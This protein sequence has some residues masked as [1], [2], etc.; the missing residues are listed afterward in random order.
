MSPLLLLVVGVAGA[1]VP[2]DQ[3]TAV[4][5]PADG[6]ADAPWYLLQVPGTWVDLLVSNDGGHFWDEIAGPPLADD[7]VDVARFGDTV[8]LLGETAVW[9]SAD[10]AATWASRA[11]P[12]PMTRVVAGAAEL[13]Y[14]GDSGVWVATSPSEA[15]VAALDV[16][17]VV[18]LEHGPFGAAAVF[19]GGEVWVAADARDWTGL[20]TVAG[21]TSV[22]IAA[23]AVYVG[24]DA[25]N[26]WRDDGAGFIAC[27]AVPID[28]E[29]PAIVEIAAA[30]GRLY[31]ATATAA[32]YVS[33]DDCA[34]FGDAV[35][36]EAEVGTYG[37]AKTSRL[38]FT[39]LFATDTDV[40]LAGWP[41]VAISRD[42]GET[43]YA[44]NIAPPD[45][46]RGLAW[47]PT[48]RVF[49]GGNDAGPVYTDD[50]GATYVVRGG[51]LTDGNVQ[52]IA[53]DP[54]DPVRVYAIVNH[55]LWRSDD[56]G[57]SW[58]GVSGSAIVGSVWAFADEVWAMWVED[59]ASR[60]VTSTDGFATVTDWPGL[61]DALAGEEPAT[62]ARVA[63]ADG[64]DAR[65]VVTTTSVIACR[66]DDAEAYTPLY[67][68]ATPP[69]SGERA[70][71]IGWPPEAATRLVVADT[72]GLYVSDDAGDT[73][74]AAWADGGDR[75]EHLLASPTHVFALTEAGRLLR[76]D[77]GGLTWADA[78]VQVPAAPRNAIVRPDFDVSDDVIVATHDGVYV[79][80]HAT[81]AASVRRWAAWQHA[82]SR[83]YLLAACAGC[84]TDARDEAA[85]DDVLVLADGAT[86][87]LAMRGD[88]FTVW[89][90]AAGTAT[91][92]VTLTDA[93]GVVVADET[94]MPEA[95]DLRAL[96]TVT[97][98]AGWYDVHLE[99]DGEGIA[100]DG[101]AAV[102]TTEPLSDGAAPIDTGDS[103]GAADTGGPDDT[104]PDGDDDGRGRRKRCGCDTGAV[105]GIGALLVAVGAL[106]LRRRR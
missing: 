7:P 4:A 76:S 79:I 83:G 67:T 87:D 43:W 33:D 1:H 105:G 40:V 104:D 3:V 92:R 85:L 99:V 106:G 82:E 35:A 45:Y 77:D 44:P 60:L 47:G 103:G 69:V 88:R 52:D 41:G 23:D 11:L 30:A 16:G 34:T 53:T 31:V 71:L 6:S 80:E 17:A 91:L 28:A 84:T 56:G 62:A 70:A 64:T 14:G 25:G 95:G 78:G 90:S 59:G 55:A 38:A 32:P 73:W 63:F 66:L 100:L 27:G 42:R 97:A 5:A 68:P 65:C 72:G 51:G 48:G 75:I 81:G 20:G 26:V 96:H 10:E 94:V 15:P 8:V 102:L 19:D 22:G 24:D 9:W 46:T 58:T 101:L 2:H 50:L 57:K 36:A 86:V 89:G 61:T 13:V 29:E 93:D 21:A 39:T 12:A 74:T 37:G 49:I 98:P 18:D 54:T